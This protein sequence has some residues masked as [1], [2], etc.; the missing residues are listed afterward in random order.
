MKEM[1]EPARTDSLREVRCKECATGSKPKDLL[2]MIR[3]AFIAVFPVTVAGV[4]AVSNGRNQ[5]DIDARHWSHLPD[6]THE[7]IW[8]FIDN[9]GNRATKTDGEGQNGPKRYKKRT[10]HLEKIILTAVS[11][12][13]NSTPQAIEA[14]TCIIYHESCIVN[15]FRLGL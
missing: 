13:D 9:L 6:F 1:I 8:T 5:Q 3:D 7:R 12:M 10:S 11:E 4:K 15:Q 2:H 14:D